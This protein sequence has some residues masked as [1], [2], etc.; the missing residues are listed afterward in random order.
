MTSW[1]APEAEPEARDYTAG[2]VNF[3]SYGELRACLGSLA[4]QTL[5][6][7]GLVVV[8]HDADPER[9]RRL[10]GEFPAVRWISGPNRGYAGGANQ[11]L[12]WT[13]RECPEAGFVLLLNPDVELSP[14]YA[15][16]LAGAMVEDPA[17]A[18][19]SGKLLRPDG[20][21]LDS[22]GIRMPRHRRPRDRGAEEPDL[23]QYDRPEPV[24]AVT[25]AAMMIR[26]SALPDLEVNGEIFDEDF[27]AYHE[28]TDLA[29]RAQLMGWKAFYVPGARATHRRRWRRGTRRRIAPEVRRHSFKN[30][31]LQMLKNER[32]GPFLRDLPVIA[33]WEALRFGFAV[34]REP[35]LL[36]GYRDAARLAPRAWAKRRIIQRRAASLRERCS[37]EPT[38]PEPPR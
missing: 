5:A 28:D 8:D 10:A 27:F 4:A 34:L 7:R 33:A 2:I 36:G 9:Q 15:A 30:H 11:I 20:R 24:F 6:P 26:R 38:A 13:A 18:V 32:A 25:G 12:A 1:P 22:A 17:L 31:Y 16:R 21:T 19:A 37:A 14:D 29:W 23:S 3:G 35:G